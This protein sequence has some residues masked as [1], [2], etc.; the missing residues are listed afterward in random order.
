MVWWDERPALANQVFASPETAPLQSISTVQ[1]LPSLTATVDLDCEYVRDLVVQAFARRPQWRV[2]V[3]NGEGEGPCEASS[4]STLHWGEYERID[5]QLVHEGRQ[6]AC[7]YCVRKGLIRKAHL[8]HNLKKWAAK[9]PNGAIA[10]GVP[11]TLIMEVD[12]VEYIDEAL[13]DVYEVRDME[14]G[15]ATWIAKPSITNQAVGIFIFDRVSA[16]REALH[17]AEGMREWVLQRYI[18]RPLLINRR[19]FHIRAYV[20]CVGSLSVYVYSESLALFAGKEYDRQSLGSLDSHLT[21][22][23]HLQR[24]S[25]P[26]SGTLAEVDAVKLLSELPQ[27]L[28]QEGMDLGAAEQCIQQVTHQMHGLIGECLEAVSNELTFFTLPNCFELFGFD[29]MVDEDWHVWLLEANAEPD[30]QQTGERLK[31]VI[32]GL[33]DG[34]LDLV[35]GP[36]EGTIGKA[37][38][39]GT[40]DREGHWMKVYDKQL[41]GR[42]IGGSGMRMH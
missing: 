14:D 42:G 32:A 5:W 35:A 3:V 10:A 30:L 20:L 28:Q 40:T 4:S 16:L 39:N 11:E 21:N 27:A 24:S 41:E 22:T 38:V 13:A 23:C 9:H 19:K 31:G 6:H 26:E 33:V 25:T 36:Q 15:S 17:Q 2:R 1:E 34:T 8:A 37:P 18:S 7:C 12:D 29:L